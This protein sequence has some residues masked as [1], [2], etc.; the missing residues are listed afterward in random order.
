MI[1]VKIM[2]PLTQRHVTIGSII[3]VGLVIW[4][5]TSHLL[6]NVS[7]GVPIFSQPFAYGPYL[8]PSPNDPLNNTLPRYYSASHDLATEMKK[9]PRPLEPRLIMGLV[10]YGRRTTVSILDC[11]LRA[12]SDPALNIGLRMRLTQSSGIWSRMVACWMGLSFSFGL[13]T[14]LT[15]Q[16]SIG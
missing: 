8:S 10:F 16:S 13:K 14:L 15:W 5:W 11:Y 4:L 9:M 6:P 12:C 7:D 2:S 1:R 3:L